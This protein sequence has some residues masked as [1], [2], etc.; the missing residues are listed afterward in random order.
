[1][2][3]IAN[4][5]MEYS[6]KEVDMGI[7]KVHTTKETFDELAK[8]IEDMNLNMVKSIEAINHVAT[9]ID[10]SVASIENAENISK[11][12]TNQIENITLAT[13]EQMSAMEQITAS[14]DH[15]AKLADDLQGIF[16]NVRF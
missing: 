4:E 13:D 15:L 16:N 3:A 5:N 2:I 7:K 10:K 11:E 1:M 12:V 6:N 14:A 8:I 9:S